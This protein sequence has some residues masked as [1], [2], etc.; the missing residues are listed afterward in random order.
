M[1]KAHRDGVTLFS[2]LSPFQKEF[3]DTMDAD[4]FVQA[5]IF[6]ARDVLHETPERGYTRR[7][8]EPEEVRRRVG[9]L[10][11]FARQFTV[12]HCKAKDAGERAV[13]AVKAYVLSTGLEG[14]ADG[15]QDPYN[16]L[17]KGSE[18]DSPFNGLSKVEFDL[19]QFYDRYVK[20]YGAEFG[21]SARKGRFYTLKVP[22]E[23][24][25]A[26]K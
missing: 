3:L 11:Q 26:T 5:V 20:G 22:T 24:I 25:A 6:N 10:F 9:G 12:K 8:P 7:I 2:L 23:K 18:Y 15:S 21:K 19:N 14:N 1:E 13:L 4:R 16:M 17:G